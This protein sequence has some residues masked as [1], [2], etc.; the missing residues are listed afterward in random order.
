MPSPKCRLVLATTTTTVTLNGKEVPVYAQV[1]PEP[2]Q[3]CP[4]CG[5]VVPKKRGKRE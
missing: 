1:V 5:R 2:G 4:T 3:H